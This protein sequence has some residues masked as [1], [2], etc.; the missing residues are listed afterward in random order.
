M[1]QWK[2]GTL[3]YANDRYML[4][5]EKHDRNVISSTNSVVT[6]NQSMIHNTP[7]HLY[8]SPIR[9]PFSFKWHGWSSRKRSD[10]TVVSICGPN[11]E[12]WD[13]TLQPCS[14]TQRMLHSL[15][16]SRGEQ[17]MASLPL[18]HCLRR[19]V[20]LP[21]WVI[22]PMSLQVIEKPFRKIPLLFQDH[23]MLYLIVSSIMLKI[24]AQWLH[25]CI[26]MIVTDSALHLLRSSG[27][28]NLNI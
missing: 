11:Q 19:K 10:T 16:S 21:Y 13:I 7:L 4:C 5:A 22:C 20:G 8:K 18:L 6:L 25:C 27:M 24:K 28:P 3:V 12:N 14:T 9:N 2:R 23:L 17:L 26:W 15:M 1:G